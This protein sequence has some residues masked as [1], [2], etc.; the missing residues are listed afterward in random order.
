[1]KISIF[2]F[3]LISVAIVIGFLAI[4]YALANLCYLKVDAYLSRWQ[5]SQELTKEELDDALATSDSMLMLHGHHPQYLNTAAK[6]YEW[7]AFKYLQNSSLSRVNL[8]KALALYQQSAALRPH[9]PLT[10]VYMANIKS[11]L[12]ALDEDFYLYVNNAVFYGPNMKQ[13]N[14]EVAKLFLSYGKKL[15]S[16]SGRFRIEQI[17]RALIGHSARYELMKY[18]KS[19]G[20]EQIL[21]NVGRYSKID[22]VTNH[23]LCK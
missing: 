12:G 6:V 20:K 9:W 17:K 10:W 16:F 11:K 19:I 14:L 3:T 1:M 8:N 18:A 23:R 4:K 2:R 7:Q 22:W 21:C 13:V 5:E 15:N